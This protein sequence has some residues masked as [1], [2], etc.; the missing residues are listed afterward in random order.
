MRNDIVYEWDLESFEIVDGLV[1]IVDHD[2]ADKLTRE[3]AL[4]GTTPG[5]MKD[6]VLVRDTFHPD[7]G[8]I[9]RQWAYV[10]DGKLPRRFVTDGYGSPGNIV[11][12]RFARELEA[13]LKDQ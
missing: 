11:P 3:M 6:L 1:E 10:V 13:A 12:S 9:D 8:L 4:E 7:D 2:H 5:N